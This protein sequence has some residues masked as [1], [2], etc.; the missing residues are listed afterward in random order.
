MSV[1]I[2]QI[3][4]I[5]SFELVKS[6]GIT[7]VD[8]WAQWCGPCL[9]QTPILEK[10]AE[11]LNGAINIA[12]VNIDQAPELAQ[13]FSITTIPTLMLFKDGVEVK[14][15]IGLHNQEELISEIDKIK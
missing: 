13:R 8:F 12:K 14:K 2:D 10:L 3:T 9:M 11:S 7:L 15:L 1:L 4:D 6:K 5:E